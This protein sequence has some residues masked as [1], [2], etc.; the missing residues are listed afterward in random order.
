MSNFNNPTNEWWRKNM[1]WAKTPDLGKFDLKDPPD[2]ERVWPKPYEPSKEA[3]RKGKE[4]CLK[5]SK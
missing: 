4:L 5:T 1:E 2:S 3:D